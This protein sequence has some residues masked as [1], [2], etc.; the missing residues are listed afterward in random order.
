[1]H[2][3]VEEAIRKAQAQAKP[4][5]PLRWLDMSNWDSEPVPERKWAIRD[6]VP[7]R[8][9]GLFSGEGGTGK[10]ILE[11]TKNVAHVV[12]KDWLGSLPQI[13][14]ALYLCAEHAM[15]E[16]HIRLASII[17]HYGTTSAELTD[18]GLHVLPLLGKDAVLC[19]ASRSV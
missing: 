6:R 19:A 10:S 12:G 8:Q 9:T 2:A 17:E 14:P 1:P 15:D 5:P 3:L 11:L 16:L 18:A 4:A 13:R 7:L